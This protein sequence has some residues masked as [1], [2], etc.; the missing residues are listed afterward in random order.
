MQVPAPGHPFLYKWHY[1]EPPPYG[2]DAN[3]DADADAENWP[4]LTRQQHQQ[5]RHALV[6]VGVLTCDDH[7]LR[8]GRLKLAGGEWTDAAR[9]AVASGSRR[10]APAEDEVEAVFAATAA[11]L[12]S[13]PPPPLPWA[14][15]NPPLASSTPPSSPSASSSSS[16]SPFTIRRL[17]AATPWRSPPRRAPSTPP[18]PPS[19]SASSSSSSSPFTIRRLVA[20]TPG[21]PYPRL[22]I[23]PFHAPFE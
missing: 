3:A 16:S 15:P 5:Q 9:A 4:P 23:V 8:I 2:A 21:R 12:P 1:A 22:M 20:A 14:F 18:P 11:A 7:L 17:A 19:P 10:L 6:R 13:L